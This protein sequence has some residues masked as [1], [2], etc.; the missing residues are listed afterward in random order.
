MTRVEY[1]IKRCYVQDEDGGEYFD[2]D[3]FSVFMRL[4]GILGK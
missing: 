1:D 4:R 3:A 2:W